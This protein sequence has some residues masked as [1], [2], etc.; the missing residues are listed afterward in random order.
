M[1]S[2]GGSWW[3]FPALVGVARFGGVNYGLQR[4]CDW[5]RAVFSRS[6]L[7]LAPCFYA[8]RRPKCKVFG[9]G[10]G[11]YQPQIISGPTVR[12]KPEHY[13][14]SEA[15]LCIFPAN[16]KPKIIS[17]PTV[18]DKLCT[19]QFQVRQ[20]ETNYIY[21]NPGRE[22]YP[23]PLHTYVHSPFYYTRRKRVGGYIY[24]YIYIYVGAGNRVYLTSASLRD[25]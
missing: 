25:V 12:D 8:Q 24:I 5:V 1:I 7:K 14:A 10:Y 11:N 21:V 3:L 18:R 23:G 2:F 16:C 13:R 20:Y 4:L 22:C 17:A 15:R 6:D 19:R 9:L